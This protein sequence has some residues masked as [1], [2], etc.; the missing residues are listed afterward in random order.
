MD[1]LKEWQ[2]RWDRAGSN[3]MN[4]RIFN[5][6]KQEIEGLK[7]YKKALMENS[8]VRSKRIEELEKENEL[9]KERFKKANQA[10]YNLGEGM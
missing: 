8:V 5:E 7:Q 2:T 1:K 3:P 10:R 6:M 9:L 4:E